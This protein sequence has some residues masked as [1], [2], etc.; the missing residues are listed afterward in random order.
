MYFESSQLIELLVEEHH[1]KDAAIFVK[2]MLLQGELNIHEIINIYKNDINNCRNSS[3]NLFDTIK[4]MLISLLQ[5]SLIN[6][7]NNSKTK[8]VTNYVYS[9]NK[10]ACL[11]I[12][13]QPK[14]LDLICSKFGLFCKEITEQLIINGIM[15]CSQVLEIIVNKL[16]SNT[17]NKL[18]YENNL[19][20][21]FIKLIQENILI[22]TDNLN[23][24]ND[25]DNLLNE[26]SKQQNIIDSKSF[27][28]PINNNE[29]KINL[30]NSKINS[31]KSK[32]NTIK[33]SIIKIEEESKSNKKEAKTTNENNTN[34]NKNVSNINNFL[35]VYFNNDAEISKNSHVPENHILLFDY[36]EQSEFSFTLNYNRLNTLL[37]CEFII[38]T[39][40]KKINPQ[41]AFICKLIIDKGN[42]S[43][44]KNITTKPFSSCDLY[45]MYPELNKINIDDVFKIMKYD[46]IHNI[47]KVYGTNDKG[48]ET[49]LIDFSTIKNILKNKLID[50]IIVQMFS[51]MHARIFRMINKCGPID[52]KNIMEIGMISQKECSTC[53]NQL[54]TSGFI[55]SQEINVKGSIVLLFKTNKSNNNNNL[56]SIIFKIIFNLKNLIN[57]KMNSNYTTNINED[58][59][60]IS[61]VNASISELDT[62]LLLL[63]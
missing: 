52:V 10:S 11:N 46:E 48:K 35:D 27:D 21:S 56:K 60:K 2:N 22:R 40:S 51:N 9:V 18:T 16:C 23:T 17:T 7:E 32:T 19:R 42:Y 43:S 30:N 14:I 58:Y 36:K 39:I 53:I 31:K 33:K 59:D 28:M 37:I 55:E 13:R 29:I 61:K 38:D 4:N 50:K 47:L 26:L 5:L 12:L 20:L 45:T 54:Y 1:S 3:I 63:E 62:L 44:I 24:I 41:V 8:E 34:N 25:H 15:T 6:C 49:Y 57:S